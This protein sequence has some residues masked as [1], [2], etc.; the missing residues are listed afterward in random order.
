MTVTEPTKTTLT[1]DNNNGKIITKSYTLAPNG[2]Y[3]AGGGY[4]PIEPVAPDYL[5]FTAVEANSSVKLKKYGSPTLPDLVTS[6]DGKIWTDFTPGATTITLDNIGDKVYFRRKGTEAGTSFSTS[7]V[8]YAYFVM[9]G[10]IAASG[11][12]MSLLDPNCEVTA[13]D[14]EDGAYCFFKLF[15]G[16]T[17]LTKAPELPATTLALSCYRDMFKDCISLN[18]ITVHFTEWEY[19][20]STM[21]W[22]SGV[23][24]TGK[25]YCPSDLDEE[26]GEDYTPTG[27]TKENL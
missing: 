25:F 2:F 8:A 19:G 27:W 23:S 12:V 1:F 9:T 26:Y 4:A 18:S 17:S 3:T 20:N 6:T 7:S 21:E 15:E 16:C 24:S 11:N 22:V 5:C 10:K 13:F 14:D